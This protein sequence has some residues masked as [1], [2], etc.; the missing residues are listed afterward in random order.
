MKFTRY[1]TMAAL[2]ASAFMVGPRAEAASAQVVPFSGSINISGGLPALSS[3]SMSANAGCAGASSTN[4]ADPDA[5]TC[6]LG[7][8]GTASGSCET[9]TAN[10]SGTLSP[11][12]DLFPATPGHTLRLKLVNAG[13]VLAITGTAQVG[14]GPVKT[15]TGTAAAVKVAGC[16]VLGSSPVS[17]SV[18]G[19]LTIV[20]P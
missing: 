19:A 2:I 1:L 7:G 3:F 16:G 18:H 6:A 14:N 12:L 17:Y 10:M 5:S 15:V 20:Q 4:V 8:T 11:V 9:W 13:G